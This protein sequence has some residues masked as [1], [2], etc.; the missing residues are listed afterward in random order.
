MREFE[1]SYSLRIP[2]A[3]TYFNYIRV[4]TFITTY[5]HKCALV[6]LHTQLFVV[7]VY[8]GQ[9]NKAKIAALLLNAK[10]QTHMRVFV[11]IKY[12]LETRSSQF[13]NSRLVCI[14]FACNCSLTC[15]QFLLFMIKLRLCMQEFSSAFV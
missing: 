6:E 2:I 1:Q 14:L 4:H 8:E 3:V 12:L 11:H 15:S 13:R 9:L 7:D 5:A 10:T